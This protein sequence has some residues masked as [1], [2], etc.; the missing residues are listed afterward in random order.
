MMKIAV[1]ADIHANLAALERAI[2]DVERWQPH[3]VIVAGD[4]VNRGPRP[5][6][7]WALIEEKVRTAGWRL[8]RGNHEEYVLAHADPHAPRQG[9][10]FEVHQASYWTFRQLNGHVPALQ[11]LPDHLSLRDEAGQELL[12][13]HGS[14][15][16]LRDGIYPETEDEALRHKIGLDERPAGAPPLALFCV[17]HT[18]RP[19]IRR[20]GKVLVVNAGSVGLPFDGDP[21]LAYARLCGEGGH[22]EAKI[23]RLDYD[24]CRALRDFELS[25]Y[26]EEAGPLVHLVWYELQCARSHLYTWALHYQERA[27]RGEISVAEA[28][29]QHLAQH[30][31]PYP[32]PVLTC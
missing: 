8:L 18:H 26:L 12:F 17:G 1:L 19:L 29:R 32:R 14:Y 9:S 25:G 10:W 24:R 23:V 16:G 5:L 7:C 21:R 3:A 6:E 30:G 31:L 20:L 28:V 11:T 15:L 22:W 27:L 4:V 13:Y 2:E